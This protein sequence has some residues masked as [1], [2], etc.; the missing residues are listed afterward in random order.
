MKTLISLL[1]ACL[2]FGFYAQAQ[3]APK[4][5]T[6]KEKVQQPQEQVQPAEDVEEPGLEASPNE[7]NPGEEVVAPEE[8]ISDEQ[9]EQRL[10]TLNAEIEQARKDG[11]KIALQKLEEERNKL[12]MGPDAEEN[13]QLPTPKE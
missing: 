13:E 8:R 9:L 5:K 12:I 4:A 7:A 2:C 3:T 10:N 11:D 1:M 6:S